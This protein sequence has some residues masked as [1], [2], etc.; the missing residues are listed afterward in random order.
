MH[1][2]ARHRRPSP[3]IRPLWIIARRWTG[4]QRG[5]EDGPSIVHTNSGAAWIRRAARSRGDQHH[6]DGTYLVYLFN[7]GFAHPLMRLGPRSCSVARSGTSST[8]SGRVVD[9]IK[10]NWPAF[11]VAI[12][13]SR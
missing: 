2:S 11:N 12:P 9:F 8:A 5:L 4:A 1:G 6:R 13:P 3:P 7:P 10:P